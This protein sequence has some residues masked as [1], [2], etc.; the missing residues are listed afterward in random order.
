MNEAIAS[1][2]KEEKRVIMDINKIF[3]CIFYHKLL[4]DVRGAQED[5]IL[6]TTFC[7]NLSIWIF[8]IQL[9]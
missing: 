8:P 4:Y 3:K 2:S 7:T 5:K 1:I 6:W 9:K